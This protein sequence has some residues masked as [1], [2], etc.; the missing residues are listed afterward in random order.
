M[1][2][3]SYWGNRVYILKYLF[4]VCYYGNILILCVL[5]RYVDKK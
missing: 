4:I 5:V 2:D 1:I 3:D